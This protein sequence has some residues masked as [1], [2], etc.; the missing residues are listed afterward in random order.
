MAPFELMRVSLAQEERGTAVLPL[1]GDGDPVELPEGGTISVALAFRVGEAVDGLVFEETRRYAGR[2][3]ATTRTTLGGYRAGGP[4][5]VH[6]PPERLPVGRAN[7]GVYEVTGRFTDS[8]GRVIGREHHR[9]RLVHQP[10]QQPVRPTEPEPAASP[11]RTSAA[12]PPATETPNGP[13]AA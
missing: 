4:Y 5:E 7:C 9:F 10:V 8:T 11:P 2:V 12:P 3:I 13:V 1:D 6:L